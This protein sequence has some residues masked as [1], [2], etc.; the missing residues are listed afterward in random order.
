VWSVALVFPL[1]VSAVSDSWGDAET[2][3]SHQKRVGFEDCRIWGGGGSS[4]AELS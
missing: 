4:K 1:T 2:V 3:N